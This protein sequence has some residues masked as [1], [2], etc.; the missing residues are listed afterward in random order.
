MTLPPYCDLLEQLIPIVRAG[1]DVVMEVYATDFIVFSKM[2]ASPVTEADRRAEAVMLP[3]VSRLLPAVPVIAEEETAAGRIP[4]I[5]ERFWLMDPLDGTREF[6]CRHDEFTVNVALVEKGV[7]V[8]GVVFAPA[9]GSLFAGVN[10]K[11]AFIED[12][13]GRRTIT[14]RQPPE[15]GLTVLKSR[16]HGCT[17]E[18]ETFLAGLNVASITGAGS[19]LK[20]CLIAAGKADVYPRFGHT[21]EWDTAAGHAILLAA[22]GRVVDSVG[23]PLLYGKPGFDNPNFIAWGLDEE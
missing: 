12:A 20:L 17:Q 4:T 10:G 22:G 6:I 19:S 21:M 9:L 14:C 11:G 16:Y 1:A 5:A 8:L 13:R 15:I 7:P 18:F 2:D 3:A 23:N